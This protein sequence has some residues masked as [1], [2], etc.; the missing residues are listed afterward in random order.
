MS[1][2]ETLIAMG[3]PEEAAK[4]AAG[5]NRNLDQALNYIENDGVGF[6]NEGESSSGA[7]SSS[8]VAA[9][10]ASPENR[11]IPAVAAGFKCEDCGAFLSNDDEMVRHAGQTKHGNFSQCDQP[12]IDDS[13]EPLFQLPPMTEEEKVAKAKEICDKIQK[14]RDLKDKKK[15][16]EEKQ[17]LMERREEKTAM[18][19]LREEAR[20]REIKEAA[21]Q[22]RRQ[23]VEDEAAR[24]KIRE[25]IRLDREER[26]AKLTPM[27]PKVA[28]VEVAAPVRDHSS[29]TLQ[30]RLLD[31]KMVRQEFKTV[32]P[33]V[34]VRAWI[35]TNQPVGSSFSLM[36]PFPRR[37]FSD[38]DMGTTLGELKLV[39]TANIVVINR[40]VPAVAAPEEAVPAEPTNEPAAQ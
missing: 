25:Q 2:T 8:T 38:D 32:E 37:E 5:N 12:D 26:K 14:A 7:S 29:T 13:R 35:E 18:L 10:A 28:K 19:S 17:E 39:P 27:P 16:E 3:F 1:V 9:E 22:L 15:T 4:A 23:K 30:I 11:A 6:E 40:G 34:M 20:E 36:T 31:G 33:L 21:A 24:E